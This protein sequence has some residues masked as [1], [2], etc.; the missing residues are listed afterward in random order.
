MLK[1]VQEGA[2]GQVEDTDDEKPSTSSSGTHQP[3]L[4]SRSV[5]STTVP[6]PDQPP[7]TSSL[8]TDTQQRTTT[9]ESTS[10]VIESPS[11]GDNVETCVI[12]SFFILLFLGVT[13]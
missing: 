12:C 4:A 6:S 1:Y 3:Q 5:D 7:S 11:A 2:H 10:P 13:L 9:S 8:G